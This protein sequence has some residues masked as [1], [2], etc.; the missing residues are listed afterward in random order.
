MDTLIPKEL[1]EAYRNT[2]FMVFS[3]AI[4]IR[5]G[6]ISESLER[7]LIAKGIRE[8]V[9]ITSINPYSRIH[10]KEENE[11]FFEALKEDVSPY[12]NYLGEGVGTDPDWEAE[13][14]L[15]ILG[16]EREKAIELGK[17]YGQNAIV[18]GEAG[19]EAELLLLR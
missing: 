14:S 6:E 8:W 17:K 4:T 5:I 13:K 18:F 9:Y 12:T 3:P 2:Q 11:Q 15:L 16:I 19:G 10:S 7:L 1:L